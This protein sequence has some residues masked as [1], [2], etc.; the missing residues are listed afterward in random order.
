MQARRTGSA[1]A[2]R[3]QAAAARSGP[4]MTMSRDRSPSAAA[5]WCTS[6][7]RRRSASASASASAVGGGGGGNYGGGGYRRQGRILRRQSRNRI[8]QA[9][10]CACGD[11]CEIRFV[12]ALFGL[13]A[14]YLVL[15]AAPAFG[16]GALG[17]RSR[18]IAVFAAR[19]DHAGQC[20]Q[21]RPRLGVSHR[22]SRRPRAR[23]D[24]AHQVS[25]P[26]RCSSR[27]A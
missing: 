25:R 4:T 10:R 12:C 9:L 22:R 18:R 3:S 26:R 1:E 24:D 8:P 2:G 27:T 5:P 19:P 14:V 15:I 23:G 20:R 11:V 17:R 6:P 7:P 16:V 21:S 13:L